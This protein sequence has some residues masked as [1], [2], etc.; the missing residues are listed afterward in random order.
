MA[1]AR[2]P[3]R[4]AAPRWQSSGRVVISFEDPVLV[5][6]E[7]ELVDFSSGGFRLAHECKNLS[8]GLEVRYKSDNASGRAR[9]IWTQVLNGQRYSGFLLL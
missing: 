5:T 7:A 2:I 4:R 9:V 1:A 8:P 6:V 3:D